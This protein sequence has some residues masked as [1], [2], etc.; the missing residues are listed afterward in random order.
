[1]ISCALINAEMV[2]AR[3]DEIFPLVDQPRNKFERSFDEN[4][5]AFMRDSI[6]NEKY[7]TYAFIENDKI[8]HLWLVEYL[9]NNE[10]EVTLAIGENFKK[11]ASQINKFEDVL[12]SQGIKRVFFV[13][14][15]AIA[16]IT[17]EHA[18]FNEVNNT[19]TDAGFRTVERILGV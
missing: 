18:G 12:R 15:P 7:F 9:P 13:C 6:E 5:I 4:D 19:K 2:N 17:L 10:A 14:R 11:C 16:K 8:F 3:W 1:M